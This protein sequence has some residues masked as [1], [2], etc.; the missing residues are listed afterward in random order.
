M[1]AK[2]SQRVSHALRSYV[3]FSD[4]LLYIFK[5]PVAVMMRK[6]IDHNPS[7]R[8]KSNYRH[9]FPPQASSNP[10]PITKSLKLMCNI[11][12]E[13]IPSPHMSTC[14]WPPIY[15]PYCPPT[16]PHRKIMNKSTMAPHRISKSL[17]LDQKSRT[18]VH[19]YH[20]LLIVLPELP[21]FFLQNPLE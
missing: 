10:L 2:V 12:T 5:W 20:L 1:D 7:K 11:R 6:F 17:K 19:W 8:A 3:N 9:S 13:T 4:H 15:I 14:P 18:H 21:L 16:A